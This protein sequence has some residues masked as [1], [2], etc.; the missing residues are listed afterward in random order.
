LPAVFNGHFELEDWIG[1]FLAPLHLICR[2]EFPGTDFSLAHFLDNWFHFFCTTEVRHA[3]G[4]TFGYNLY[5]FYLSPLNC[6]TLVV[7]FDFNLIHLNS[8]ISLV[9]R[10]PH[11]GSIGWLCGGPTPDSGIFGFVFSLSNI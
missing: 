8:L 5:N 1:Q 6:D 7:T 11:T 2:V 3:G 10:W 4:A 9:L